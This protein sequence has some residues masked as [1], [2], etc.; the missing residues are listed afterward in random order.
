M[1]Y[2]NPQSHLHCRLSTIRYPLRRQ[3]GFSFAEVMFA[4]V[5]LGIGFIM[6]A[7]IFPVAIQQTQATGEENI[8]AIAAR[9]AAGGIIQVPTSV[10]NPAYIPN[11]TAAQVASLGNAITV[12][13]YPVFPPTVKNFYGATPP[14]AVVVPF[15]GSRWKLLQ[16][17]TI[18]ISDQ[19]Y[20]YVP[21]YKRENGSGAAELIVIA[22]AVRNHPV[23]STVNDALNSYAS[24][25]VTTSVGSLDSSGGTVTAPLP[26]PSVTTIYPDTITIS[27]QAASEGCSVTGPVAVGNAAPFQGRTYSCG[28]GTNGTFQINPGDGLALTAGADGLWGNP[29]PIR[30]TAASGANFTYTSATTLQPQVAYALLQATASNPAGQITI[31]GSPANPGTESITPSNVG[32]GAF[33]IVADDY[34]A[35]FGAFTSPTAPYTLPQNIPSLGG[36]PPFTVGALNG[37]IFRL[38]AMVGPGSIGTVY[39]LDPAY[40]MLPNGPYSASPDNVPSSAFAPNVAANYLGGNFGIKVYIV[41][42]GQVNGAYTG[43]TQD[44]GVFATYFP[45][46]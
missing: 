35:P 40:G 34:P 37:R 16:S 44:T 32:T 4:V 21:F 2:L 45:V 23:Y 8:A 14:P 9:D 39:N 12:P 41:G 11:Y 28:L 46:K 20:A 17:D 24:A 15:T 27:G 29:F 30:D 38:G 19:R 7:A 1:K 26:P 33:V 42:V 31:F 3:S 13:T 25:S 5:I 6:V 22:V 18:Q 43:P 10:T 36:L